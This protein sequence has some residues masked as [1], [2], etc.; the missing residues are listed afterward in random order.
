MG[1]YQAPFPPVVTSRPLLSA[2]AAAIECD[3]GLS[4]GVKSARRIEQAAGLLRDG[5]VRAGRGVRDPGA[6]ALHH[7]APRAGLGESEFGGFAESGCPPPGK[8]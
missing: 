5:P 7:A 2:L 3:P 1:G 6:G 8:E 4:C